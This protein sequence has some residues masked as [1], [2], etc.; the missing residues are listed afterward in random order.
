MRTWARWHRLEKTPL[1]D[2]DQ[3]FVE[4]I[5]DKSDDYSRWYNDVVLKAELADYSPV[6]GC[7]VIRPYGYALWENMQAALDARIKATGHLNAYFPLFIPEALLQKEA[8]HVAGFNPEVAWITAAGSED[9]ES[10]YAVRPTSEA[11]IGTMYGKWIQSW[12]DLPILINQWANVVRWEK[13]TY[14]F[15]RTTEFLWQEGHTAHRTEDEAMEEVLRMLDVYRDFAETELAMPVIPGRK[16]EAEKF[17]GASA[18]FS[19]EAMMGDGR[20]LQ[21]GTSH[22]FGQEFA[23]AFDISFLD[24]DGQRRFAWTTSWGASTRLIGG[25]IMVHGDDA[26]LILPPRVAPYQAV[27][28]PIFRRDEERDRVRQAVEEIL[29]SLRGRV[30]VHVDWSDHTPGWKF[31]EWELKGVPIRLELGPRDVA[32][33]QVVAVRRDS[34]VKEPIPVGSLPERLPQLLDAIQQ[35]L[36][37]RALAFRDQRTHRIATLD[38]LSR[39]IEEERGFFWAAWCGESSCEAEVKA[40]TGATLRCVPLDGG[41]QGGLCLVCNA[42]SSQTAVFARAY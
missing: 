33:G 8:E 27:I 32:Q 1:T 42:P 10:R 21:S 28:V 9:L 2:N 40:T 24:M 30:R 12:R 18:T 36:Y 7:M 35:A 23:K 29:A 5:V 16:S 39:Q 22:S 25:L 37:E 11:I 20:A 4:E 15:L 41:S 31:N 38:Q 6:R 3:R 17:A 26:G 13:R 34:R 19:V 14:L